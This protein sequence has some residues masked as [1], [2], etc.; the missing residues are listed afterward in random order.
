M[1]LILLGAPGAGKGT[2]GALL[3]KRHGVKRIVT[4]DILRAAVRDD[5]ELGREARRYMDAGELVPDDLILDM[6]R[7]VLAD[8]NGGFIMDGFPRTLDQATSLDATLHEMG[9]AVG[10]VVVLEVPDEVVVKRIAGRRSCP[11]CGTVYNVYFEPPR[12]SDVCDRCGAALVQRAD[13]RED[14]VLNRMRV[15]RR[16]TQPLIEYYQEGDP[17]VHVVDADRSVEKVHEA[18]NRAI[19]A[20]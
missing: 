18:I 2:Q 1:R 17:D 16:Q 15:F 10:N 9:L 8:A 12:V 14:T 13:D 5:T 6:L 7:E 20:G 19:T 3:A 4:G 11:Q